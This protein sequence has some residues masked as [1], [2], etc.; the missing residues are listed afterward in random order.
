[1]RA[2]GVSPA[3]ARYR[4]LVSESPEQDPSDGPLDASPTPTLESIPGSVPPGASTRGRYVRIF[5]W[6]VTIAIAVAIAW[7]AVTLVSNVHRG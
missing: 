5:G 4:D 7:A 3:P 2:C 6:I 1:M